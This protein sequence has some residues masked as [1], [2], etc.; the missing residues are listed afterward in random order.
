MEPLLVPVLVPDGQGSLA[1]SIVAL[2]GMIVPLI[3]LAFVCRIFW[4]A[5]KRDEAERRRTAEWRN[6]HSS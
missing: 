3:V 6:A 5:H 2:I 4:R 1:I